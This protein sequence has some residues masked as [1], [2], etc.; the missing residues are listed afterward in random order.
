MLRVLFALFLARVAAQLAVVLVHPRWLPPMKDWYSGL[1]AY[2]LL[3][4]AQIAILILMIFMIRN[5]LRSRRLGIGI[6]AFATLYAVSMLVRLIL[7]RTRHPE[8]LWYEGGM[9]PILF[10]WVLAGFLFAYARA[11]PPAAR[12]R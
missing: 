9:I 2:P 1:I 6:V 4:P 3:L 7:L 8:L 5:P 12:T 11:M 10:H